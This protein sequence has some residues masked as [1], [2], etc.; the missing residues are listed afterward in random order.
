MEIILELQQSAQPQHAEASVQTDRQMNRLM[1][2][3][4][5]CQLWPFGCWTTIVKTEMEQGTGQN[6]F[7]FH[8]TVAFTW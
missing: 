7:S 6:T 4:S 8:A 3:A 5:G 2:G 1:D